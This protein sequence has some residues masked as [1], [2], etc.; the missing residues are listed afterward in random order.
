MPA[1]TTVRPSFTP[2]I[3]IVLASDIRFLK[4]APPDARI[5]DRPRRARRLRSR[6]VGVGCIGVGCFGVRGAATNLG[7]LRLRD[8]CCLRGVGCG[9][10]N[11]KLF[12]PRKRI[13][14][15]T[16]SGHK[17]VELLPRHI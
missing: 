5:R 13:V 16:D 6:C 9:F 15:L 7:I 2:E 12:G 10:R 4:R 14:A 11:R 17:L 8:F 1:K 3:L